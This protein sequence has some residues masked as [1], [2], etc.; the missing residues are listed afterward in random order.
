M[1]KLP[2]VFEF[3]HGIASLLPITDYLFIYFDVE[4]KPQLP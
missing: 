4:W 1:T 3:D 2:I